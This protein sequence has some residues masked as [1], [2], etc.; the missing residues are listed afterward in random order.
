MY[1]QQLP[2]VLHQIPK[3]QDLLII[4]G[5]EKVPSYYYHIADYN[6]SIGNQPHSEVAALAIILDR[7]TNGQ[8]IHKDFNGDITIIPSDEGKKV[9]MKNKEDQ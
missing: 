3:K 7:Y 4:L 1:G 2:Q 8:W 5:A 6:V 9:K